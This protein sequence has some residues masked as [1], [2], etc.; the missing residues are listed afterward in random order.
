MNNTISSMCGMWLMLA[1]LLTFTA[2]STTQPPS[3]ITPITKSEIEKKTKYL[4]RKSNERKRN[5]LAHLENI[6]WPIAQ[7]NLPICGSF[8]EYAVGLTLITPSD[9]A[10]DKYGLS[11]E[12]SGYQFDGKPVVQSVIEGSPAAVAGIQADDQIL[13]IGERRVNEQKPAAF[14]KVARRHLATEARKG[15]PFQ[16]TFLRD[17][18]MEEVTLTPVQRCKYQLRIAN[19]TNINAYTNG[20][21]I[22]FTR[23]LIEFADDDLFLQAVFAHELAHGIYQH[24]MRLVPRAAGG[25]MLDL[26]VLSQGI[27]T[28]GIFTNIG[29]QLFNKALEREADYVAYYLLAN[30]G[31][32]YTRAFDAWATLA[33]SYRGGDNRS[34]THP[35]HAERLV[36]QDAVAKEIQH[37][38]NTGEPL[39]PN[40]R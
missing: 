8:T 14:T 33:I 29:G 25:L 18:K 3:H 38:I 9:F 39:V 1:S 11:P 16:L 32:D 7:K 37:K 21:L 4:V 23:G 20:Y 2:C 26:A 19:T 13:G 27:W 6:F 40:R 28:N 22:S 30:A 24:Q 12:D 15:G 17:G 35:T 5:Q 36:I 34:L 10:D 31:L